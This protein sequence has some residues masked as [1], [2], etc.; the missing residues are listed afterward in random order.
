MTRLTLVFATLLLAGCDAAKGDTSSAVARDSAGVRI[1]ENRGAEALGWTVDEA[2]MVD[3]GGEGEGEAALFQVTDAKR[4]RDGRIVIASAGNHELRVYGADGRLLRRAGREGQGPGEFSSPFW[5]GALRGDSIGVWDAGLGRLTVFTPA[6][7]Y[8]RVMSPA[9]SLG[10][11]PMAQGA[12]ADGRV[13]IAAGGAGAPMK[14]GAAMRDTQTYIVLGHDGALA[15]TLGRFPDTEM[16]MVGSPATGLLVRPLPFGRQTVAAVHGA[17]VY[18][19]TGNRYE[20][21]GYEPGRGL[22]ALIRADRPALAVTRRDIDDYR[23]TLVT[24]GG[25]GDATLR[26]QQE[27]ALDDAPYPK[28][29]APLTGLAAD[30]DGNLWVEEAR[31]PGDERGSKW[32]VFAPDGTTRGTVTIPSGLAVKQIGRDWILGVAVD[33]DEVEHVRLHR[34]TRAPR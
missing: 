26:R 17:R 3:I 5:V 10:M 7:D 13:V 29:M 24:L 22:R 23:R 16:V 15:D 20:I 33:D 6:G 30:A 11:F 28:R 14:P 12:L 34:L 27:K 2:P 25:G 9:G 19:A 18:L 4:L 8:A 31:R 1:V 32:T 21:A